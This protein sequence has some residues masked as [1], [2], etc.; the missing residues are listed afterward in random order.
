MIPL[1]IVLRTT[2]TYICA[3]ENGT[4]FCVYSFVQVQVLVLGGMG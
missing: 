3:V 4:G 2:I 1:W